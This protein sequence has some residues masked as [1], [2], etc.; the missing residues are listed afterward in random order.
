M[1]WRRCRGLVL[2]L[3]AAVTLLLPQVRGAKDPEVYCGVCRALVAEI[4]WAIKKVDPK[5]T[6][7]VGSFR[8]SPD[9]SQK[10]N[11]ISY[12]RSETHLLELFETICSNMDDYAL[13][14]DPET[15]KR[16]Y[17][18]FAPRD[19]EKLGSVDFK[20]FKFDPENSKSLK[21]VCEGIVEE[22]EDE[23]ISLFAHEAD[24][25]ADK[26]CSEKSEM[27]DPPSQTH[28]PDL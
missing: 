24:H 14:V 27:C 23:I 16:T 9:G 6:I 13:Y 5:K 21:F 10:P 12:A 26:L 18:R 8:I 7:Q 2:L 17:M 4:D 28:H 3:L 22:Y 20:N 11:E 1:G 15:Q 25:V 19:S